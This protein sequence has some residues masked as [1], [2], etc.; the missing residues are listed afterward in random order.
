MVPT[1]LLVLTLITL[2][3]TK[4]SEWLSPG[5]SLTFWSPSLDVLEEAWKSVWISVSKGSVFFE[6]LAGQQPSIPPASL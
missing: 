5:L 4:V 2:T 3:F 1:N 6:C